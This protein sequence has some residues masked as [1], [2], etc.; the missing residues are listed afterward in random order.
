[1]T[2]EDLH[3]GMGRI[4]W[5]VRFLAGRR[6][7]GDPYDQTLL[8]PV[9]LMVFSARA[10]DLGRVANWVPVT[11]PWPVSENRCLWRRAARRPIRL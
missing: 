4:G 1:M 2:T 3:F 7:K 10:N 9:I 8:I 5:L 11:V 6:A